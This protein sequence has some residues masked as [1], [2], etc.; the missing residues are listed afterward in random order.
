MSEQTNEETTAQAPVANVPDVP[1]LPVLLKGLEGAP[2]EVQIE[3]WKQRH[4]EVF[5]SGFSETE[6]FVWHPI[7]RREY[8]TLQKKMNQ[9]MQELAQRDPAAASRLSAEEDP[10]FEEELVQSC[11][12]WASN[13]RVLLS[14]AG[15]LPT[16]AEQ[17]LVSS[18]FVAPAVA[19]MLV[20][21][22]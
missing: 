17:I 2:S 9:K 1:D 11:I 14:K 10:D 21:K 7:G 4:G 16:L 19:S 3:E 15:S 12:L 8:T 6:I 18:N 22:L 5:V 20:A 13:E